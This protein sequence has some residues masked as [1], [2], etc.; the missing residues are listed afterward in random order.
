[1][2]I[3]DDIKRDY[4]VI[5]PERIVARDPNV[6]LIFHATTTPDNLFRRLGWNRISAVREGRI[7]DDLDEDLIFRPGPRSVRGAWDLY[8]RLLE[9]TESHGEEL[10]KE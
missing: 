4:A 5:N 3:G 10:D 1:V 9:V 8:R 2:N 7:V 6:I